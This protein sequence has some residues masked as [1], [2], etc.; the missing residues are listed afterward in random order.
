MIRTWRD[1][2]IFTHQASV[3]LSCDVSHLPMMITNQINLGGVRIEY[4][5]CYKIYSD[6]I[7]PITFMEH[8]FSLYTLFN[9]KIMIISNERV[10]NAILML[11]AKYSFSD[12]NLFLFYILYLYYIYF[13]T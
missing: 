11:C 8:L 1:L 12:S 3:T 4:I 9:L 10:A 2:S 13:H 5:S 6:E 7:L